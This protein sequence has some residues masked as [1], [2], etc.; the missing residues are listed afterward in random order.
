MSVGHVTNLLQKYEYEKKVKIVTIT[1]GHSKPH[2]LKEEKQLLNLNVFQIHS[3]EL[4][5]KIVATTKFSNLKLG[6]QSYLDLKT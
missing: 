1:W 4:K 5:K 6:T 2:L 3:F